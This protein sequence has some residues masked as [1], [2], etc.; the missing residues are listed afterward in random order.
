M[1]HIWR[2]FLTIADVPTIQ[3]PKKRPSLGPERQ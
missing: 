3:P 2:G 1:E